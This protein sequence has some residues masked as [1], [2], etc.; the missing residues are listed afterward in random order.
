MLRLYHEA[1]VSA[2]EEKNDVSRGRESWDRKVLAWK[3]YEKGFGLVNQM[4]D[5]LEPAKDEPKFGHK[6]D[7]SRSVRKFTKSSLGWEPTVKLTSV[8]NPKDL[9]IW[10]TFIQKSRLDQHCHT[11]SHL[12][13]HSKTLTSL[14]DVCLSK[15]NFPLQA[16]KTLSK[17]EVAALE[18]VPK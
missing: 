18:C 14:Q 9:L 3:F 4:S 8:K 2:I 7:H 5:E 17:T 12:K 11:A 16:L 10:A 1:E 15:D 13:P 6:I